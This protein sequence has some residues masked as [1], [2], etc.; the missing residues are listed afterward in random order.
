M[1]P[2]CLSI[3]ISFIRGLIPFMMAPD[4]LPKAPPPNPMAL[5]INYQHMDCGG[6]GTC[7]HSVYVSIYLL[8]HLFISVCT[9][10]YLFFTLGHSLHACLLSCFSCVWL[11]ATLWAVARPSPLSMG[12]SRQEYWNG[13]P[14]LPPGESSPPGDQTQISHIS[15]R[16]FTSWATREAQEYWSG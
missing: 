13:L 3:G 2:C 12:F 9:H 15:G 5:G 14:F 7:K 8:N 16:F 6:W 4:Y 11:F 1:G 10:S